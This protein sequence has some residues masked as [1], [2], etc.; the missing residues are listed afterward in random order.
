[1]NLLLTCST[2]PA[3]SA[4]AVDLW[5]RFCIADW[6]P[7]TKIVPYLKFAPASEFASVDAIV[8]LEPNMEM[9]FAQRSDGRLI[10]FPEMSPREAHYCNAWISREI[11]NLPESCAMRDGRKWKRIPQIVLSTYGYRHEAYDGLDVE[12]VIDVTEQML[13]QGYG[14]SV[15]WNKIEEIVNSYHLRAM[16]E[17]KR[18]GFIITADR[19]IYR[20]KRAF[21]KKDSH[22][23]EFYFGGKDK[24]K[25]RGFVTIGREMDGADYEAYLFEQLLNDPKSGE[26]EMHH[27]FE[28]HGNFLAEAMMG[29]PISHQPY[30]PTNKQTPDFSISPIV[31]RDGEDSVKLLE[32]KGPE[33]SVL[34]NKRHLHRGLAPAVI[35]ALA[36]VND[37]AE[38]LRELLNFQ[39]INKALGFLPES[40][41]RAVLIGRTPEAADTSLWKKRKAEQPSVQIIT[42]DEILQENQD[43]LAWRRRGWPTKT[44][45]S[46]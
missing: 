34:A 42:Y 30:F 38:S 2:V 40:S 5:N 7:G 11:R 33:A 13:F 24:R 41:Q 12:F 39:A 29:V 15:T 36:Q 44:Y 4:E 45:S 31:P 25:Y 16:S 22:E 3:F 35:Q 6:M 43:R 19:G 20:V 9:G 46:G 10:S 37:Y 8:F 18:V 27:F 17:Y 14:S 32:L 26:R 21:R 23:S 28:E 1:M